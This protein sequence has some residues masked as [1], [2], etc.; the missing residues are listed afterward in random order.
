M[1]TLSRRASSSSSIL[2]KARL[3]TLIA[4]CGLHNF[5]WRRGA[6]VVDDEGG[7]GAQA[8]A[9]GVFA[10]DRLRCRARRR[11]RRLLDGR[12]HRRLDLFLGTL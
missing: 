10:F 9:A 7:G 3:N 11:A 8:Q 5:S 6:A 4:K 12:R 2:Q 1:P